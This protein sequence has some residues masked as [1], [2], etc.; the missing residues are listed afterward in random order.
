M[1]IGLT[2]A[3]KQDG[4]RGFELVALHG[5]FRVGEDPADMPDPRRYG[6]RG[7]ASAVAFMAHT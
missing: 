4:S 1:D 3:N 7:V 6:V 5:V 2:D